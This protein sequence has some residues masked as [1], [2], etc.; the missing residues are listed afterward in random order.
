MFCTSDNGQ[1]TLV[2]ELPNSKFEFANT[3]SQLLANCSKREQAV[4][5]SVATRNIEF[6]WWF[7]KGQIIMFRIKKTNP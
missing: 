1:N 3:T 4:Q 5:A 6:I 7:Y 2:A